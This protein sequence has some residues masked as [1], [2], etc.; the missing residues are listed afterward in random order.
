[1]VDQFCLQVDPEPKKSSGSHMFMYPSFCSF[2]F[3]NNRAVHDYH[4]YCIYQNVY[5]AEC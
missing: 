3:Y 5:L 2:G 4:A 1:M